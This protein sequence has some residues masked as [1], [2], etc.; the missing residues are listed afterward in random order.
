MTLSPRA[1]IPTNADIKE[2]KTSL[3]DLAFEASVLSDTD[4]KNLMEEDRLQITEL[5]YSAIGPASI[6]LRLGSTLIKYPPQT[7]TIGIDHPQGHEISITDSHYTLRPGEFILGMTKEQVS[8][9]DG[10]LGVIETK[11]NVARAGIQV[12]SNDGHID[13]GFSGNITLEIVNLHRD[14]VSIEL[15][16]DMFICQLFIGKLFSANATTYRGKYLYQKKPTTYL[17]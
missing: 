11:G 7:I 14:D 5:E 17:P 12:H 6:D 15:V 16:P 2:D 13:P 1:T 10:Y 3:A 9:P 4:I 8:I